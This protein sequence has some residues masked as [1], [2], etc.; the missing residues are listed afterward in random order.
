MNKKKYLFIK[1]ISEKHSFFFFTCG[2]LML[3]SEIWKQLVLT[4]ILGNACYNWWYFPF[5]LCS[6]P[7]YLLLIYP[8]FRQN[9]F[10]KT[11][12]VFL[13][14][15]SLLG[16]IA[17]FADTS[18]LHYPL[19][20]LTLH[21][22][23][24][25]VFLIVLG[26]SAGT[27]YI[28]SLHSDSQR[29]LSC[30]QSDKKRTLFSRA[31]LPA[32]PLRPFAYSTFLYLL[33]CLIAELLNLSLDQ[34]GTINMFYINPDYRMQQIIFRELLPLLGNAGTILVYIAST[35]LGAL[36]LF[37]FWKLIWRLVLHP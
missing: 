12:L 37:L 2:I 23:I 28:C 9:V 15:Y 26:I 34:F 27:V 36:I 11:L 16:G 19:T 14:C 7:M 30:Q 24:W 5:Q 21:S 33:C 29:T 1:F 6:I 31:H 17:A 13:M 4:F 32:F 35:I 20:S 25:H 10:R 8:L 18:G 22:Y 3:I